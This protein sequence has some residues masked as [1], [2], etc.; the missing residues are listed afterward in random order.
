MSLAILCPGQG[1]QN[2]AMF[3]LLRDAPAARPLLEDLAQVIG[4]DPL[5][6]PP[7]AG[8]VNAI[9]QPLVCAIALATFAL[10]KD[11]I[12]AP[13]VF[14]GYSIGEL[15]AHGC[16]GALAPGEVL[17]LA[18]RRAELMDAAGPA[19]GGLTAVRGLERAALATLCAR[20]GTTIAIANG[21]DR[22]IAGGALVAL[23]DLERAVEARGGKVTRLAI[24]IASHTPLMAA[25]QAPFRALLEAAGW[26]SPSAPVLAGVSGLAVRTRAKA[27]EALAVQIDHPLDWAA[28][29]DALDERRATVLLELG[30]GSGLSR[31]ARERRP[32]L[33][34]RS[35][36][37]FASIAGIAAWVRQSL[38]R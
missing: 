36:S 23:A 14:A 38:E 26:R 30:P 21:D 12:P 3:D 13:E 33:A 8:H 37:E 11:L 19:P 4:A 29:L 10:L 31:M 28:C 5:A 1:D 2:P 17:R 7:E 20:T 34:A 25:A 18:R 22:F 35:A 6:L 32:H 9:A 24:A 27:I 15:A 16:A